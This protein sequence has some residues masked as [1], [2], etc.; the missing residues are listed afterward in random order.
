M[1][2]INELANTLSKLGP[3]AFGF[4]LCIASGYLVKLIPWIP[5]KAIP[6]ICIIAG[7]VWYPFLTS[8]G[9][10]S[11]DSQ[12]PWVRIIGTGLIIGVVAW[13]THNAV[14]WRVENWIKIKLQG[15]V[16]KRYRKKTDGS[17]EEVKDNE[18]PTQP[19]E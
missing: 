4:L 19:K 16:S 14:I 13:M 10:V 5:N 7:P 2:Y 1:N 17:F 11:P 15:S 6:V 9:R 8:T 3:E 18:P 12:H